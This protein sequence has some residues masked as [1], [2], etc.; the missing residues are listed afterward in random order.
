MATDTPTPD[1][2]DAERVLLERLSATLGVG[3]TPQRLMLEGGAHVDIGG[4]S[5]D[6]SVLVEV[7]APSGGL[8]GG[9]RH[10][11]ATAILK[12]ITVA[13][14][15]PRPRLILAVTDPAVAGWSARQSWHAA[16][17]VAWGIELFLIDGDQVVP[18]RIDP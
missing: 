8:K 18:V 17:V 3:V 1:P 16:A 13:L 10:K 11:I 6:E 7:F 4:V 12:L 14:R 15:D 5:S 2:A 9:Q